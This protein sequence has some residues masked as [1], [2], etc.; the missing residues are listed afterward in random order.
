MPPRCYPDHMITR[1]RFF[2]SVAL[3]PLIARAQT[4][5][6]SWGSFTRPSPTR[7]PML[8]TVLMALL[9]AVSGCGG[10]DTSTDFEL[11][12]SDPAPEE[13]AA[14]A[15]HELILEFT[16][17]VVAEGSEV[18]VIAP[19]G[20]MVSLREPY[21]QSNALIQPLDEPRPSGAYSVTWRATGTDGSTIGG[22]F[23][24]TAAQEY[25]L[26]PE[27]DEETDD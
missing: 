24:F 16:E 26:P 22:T 6:T 20:T 10:D 2:P 12:R 21:A 4:A 27:E 14:R 3:S 5:Q 13:Q 1:T 8:V 15:P 17:D 9:L 7:V 19:D 11:V 23:W 25:P 18:L